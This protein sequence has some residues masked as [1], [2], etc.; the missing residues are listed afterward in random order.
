MPDGNGL[1]LVAA[2][3]TSLPA[4]AAIADQV[5]GTP[6]A[7]WIKAFI[8]V[9]DDEVVGERPGGIDLTWVERSERPGDALAEAIWTDSERGYTTAWLCAEGG[10]VARLR[11]QLKDETSIDRRQVFA[12]GY[13][14][15]GSPTR[16]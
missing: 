14:Q 4:L 8:E 10:A 11:K 2:D 9:E 7:G 13:W 3:E 12:K 16:H 5:R 6:A 1:Q 15:R